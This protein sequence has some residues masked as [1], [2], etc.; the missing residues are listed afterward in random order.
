MTSQLLLKH[1][2]IFFALI[3]HSLTVRVRVCCE[4][5][6]VDL[7]KILSF[8]RNKIIIFTSYL[9]CPW[10]FEIETLHWKLFKFF[11]RWKIFENFPFWCWPLGFNFSL[12]ISFSLFLIGSDIDVNDIYFTFIALF[13]LTWS[14]IEIDTK[15]FFTFFRITVSL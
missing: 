9:V 6:M 14:K 10:I 5:T 15:Q 11:I 12:S 8:P 7:C 2:R 4:I 3:L 1:D 13:L